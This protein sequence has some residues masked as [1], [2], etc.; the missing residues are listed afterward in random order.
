MGGRV[1]YQ[2]RPWDYTIRRSDASLPAD[3]SRDR[4]TGVP[5]AV[6]A[7]RATAAGHTT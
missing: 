4:A 6:M 1:R 3:V 5:K 7:L 2:R